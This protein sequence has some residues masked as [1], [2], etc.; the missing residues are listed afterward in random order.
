LQL[1]VFVD[2]N[3][4]VITD[5]AVISEVVEITVVGTRNEV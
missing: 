3:I 4:V 1:G 2:V 5:V